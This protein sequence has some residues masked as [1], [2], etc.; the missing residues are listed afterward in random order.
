MTELARVAGREVDVAKLHDRTGGNPF[1]ATEVLAVTEGA[2]P[3]S[4]VDAVLARAGR[5][6]PGARQALDAAAVIGPRCEPALLQRV[7]DAS[8]ADIDACLA[9]GMLVPSE[10]GVAFRHELAREALLG[11]LPITAKVRWHRRTVD[12]LIEA[13]P[14]NPAPDYAAIA[15][16]AEGAGDIEAVLRYAPI[17]ARQ[18]A[19]VHAHR[20]AVGQLARVLRFAHALPDAD[21]VSLLEAYAQECHATDRVPEAIEAYREAVE[22]RRAHTELGPAAVDLARMARLLVVMGRNA[23]SEQA[24]D[25]AMHLAKESGDAKASAL[26]HVTWAY[27]RMLN[28]DNEAARSG[29]ARALE[30]ARASGHEVVAIQAHN[31][32]G[33][34]L[35]LTGRHPEGRYQLEESLRLAE[36]CGH[37]ELAAEALRNLGTAFGEVYRFAEADRWLDRGIA[38]CS[39]RD[40]DYQ[41]MYILSW[42]ALSHAYQGRWVR[43]AEDAAV[44]VQRPGTAAIS[45]IMA[46]AALGRIRSRRGDPEAWSALDQALELADVTGTLQRVGPVRAARA[47]LAWLEGDAGRC[48]REARAAYALA[49]DKAHPWFVGE[50]AYWRWKAGDLD[51]APDIAADPFRWQIEG[52]WA[53][54]AAA[55]AELL[56]PYEEARARAESGNHAASAEAAR[57]FA[58][59]G[60]RPALERLAANSGHIDLPSER[61]GPRPSTL[62]NPAGLTTRQVRVL[63]LVADGLTNA[64]IAERLFR[65]EKTIEHHLSA[66]FA[67]L[68]VRNRTEA[69]QRAIELRLA[70]GQR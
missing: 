69:A 47:E 29:A 70:S 24:V 37:A 51:V 50:L 11:V 20:E 32:L 52:R 46:L 21:R 7:A 56:C 67:K 49:V 39:E 58:E 38:Y 59:L 8:N 35:I 27:L 31:V 55:W 15:H 22:I 18:A 23:E 3:E 5:L 68:D 42:R 66:I 6:E 45:R 57:L 12:E 4:V 43:A 61:R 33:C 48:G 2:L 44:V 9:S 34:V 53:D 41:R 65:S 36:E 30:L 19:A 26:A 54:A 40:L 25:D 14:S 64:E 60:A 28:R 17:A 63:C 62:R 13:E 1:Y 16:H 10:R